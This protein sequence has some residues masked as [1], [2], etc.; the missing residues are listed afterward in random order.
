MRIWHLECC[1]CLTSILGRRSWPNYP[2]CSL[3]TCLHHLLLDT[4]QPH[5]MS[6]TWICFIWM[7]CYCTKC[8]IYLAV[9]FSRWRL[10]EWFQHSWL[11]NTFAE[12]TM[13]TPH[14]QHRTCIIWPST[15]YTLLPRYHTALWF[16]TNPS[17]T[18]VP[19]PIIY[20][21]QFR[22]WPGSRQHTRT[23]RWRRRFPNSTCRWWTLDNRYSTGK[24]IL[25]TWKWL[26]HNV[27]QYPCSYGNSDTVSYMDSLDLNNILD[28][29]DYM[30]TTNYD[31][32][33]PGLEEVPYWHLNSGLLEHLLDI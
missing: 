20:F 31:E 29:K 8:N 12:N 28:Y 16:T 13:H 1:Y 2:R 10:R 11:T 5:T 3:R 27:C 18:S 33:L 14:F 7:F 26:S 6:A 4:H 21:Q 30:M 15:H 25:H 17:Q 32:E 23:L 24:N 19:P 22:E 9:I